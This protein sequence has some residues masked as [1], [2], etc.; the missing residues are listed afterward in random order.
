MSRLRRFICGAFGEG[1]LGRGVDRAGWTIQ[2][3]CLRAERAGEASVDLTAHL[4]LP[5]TRTTTAARASRTP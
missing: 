3:R 2:R 1:S 5:A 4:P